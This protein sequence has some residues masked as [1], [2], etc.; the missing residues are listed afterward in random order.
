MENALEI[1]SLSKTFRQNRKQIKALAGISLNIKKGE[2]FGLLGPN[3][4]GKSTLLNIITNILTPDSGNVLILQKNPQKDKEILQEI[5]LAS[6]DAHFHWVLRVKD[7]LS[8]YS[9]A[10][11]L[12]RHES[13]KRIGELSKFF[14]IDEIM[15]RRFDSLSTGQKMRLV[16][17][18]SLINNPKVL[19]L[20]EPTLGLDPNIAIKLRSEI[21]RINKKL[22]V[23][24]VLT[25][26]YMQE[27]EEL[28][29]RVAFINKGRIVDI[30][31]VK[32]IMKKHKN[33]QEYFLKMVDE[34]EDA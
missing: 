3:G 17:A 5:S 25:S 2:I 8:F 16:F 22:G 13:K 20:D 30:G 11:G 14:E 28:C 34:N 24:V 7:I 9:L 21:K 12:E 6:G 29:H 4:A 10:Y 1:R 27:V 18:K 33:M 15:N 31:P 26:H 23:T 19:L 32:K